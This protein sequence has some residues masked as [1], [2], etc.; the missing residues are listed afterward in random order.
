MKET[1]NDHRDTNLSEI[2]KEKEK[3]EVRIGDSSEASHIEHDT[4]RTNK[5]KKIEEVQDLRNAS[6]IL[7]HITWPRG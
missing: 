5:R 2:L 6:E 1:M 4:P 3:I 7:L